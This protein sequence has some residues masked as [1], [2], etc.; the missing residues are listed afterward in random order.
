MKS[1]DPEPLRR[2]NKDKGN[3]ESKQGLAGID[4]GGEVKRTQNDTATGQKADSKSSSAKKYIGN[5]LASMMGN[6][7]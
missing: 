3:Q 6:L 5:F 2:E 1:G 4:T 7:K